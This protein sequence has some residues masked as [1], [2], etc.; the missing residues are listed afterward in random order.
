MLEKTGIKI[1]VHIEYPYNTTDVTPLV[2]K[3]V[4]LNPDT[5]ISVPYFH[6]RVLIAKAIKGVGF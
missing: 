6:D 4:E 5:V 2:S 3:L 1:L